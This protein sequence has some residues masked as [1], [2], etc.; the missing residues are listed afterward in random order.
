MLAAAMAAAF[1]WHASRASVKAD[2]PEA[3]RTVPGF[4]ALLGRSPETVRGMDVAQL[5]LWSAEGLPGAEGVDV[6]ASMT[7]L[8]NMAGRARTETERHIYRFKAN[9]AEFE[10]SEGFFRMI[11]L[12]VVLGEDFQVKYAAGKIGTAADAWTGDGFFSDASRGF[13]HGLSGPRREGTCSSLPVLYVAVGRRLGYP[14]KLVTT[15]GYLFVRW[16]D[17]KERFNIEATSRGVNR[18][19]DEYYRHWPLEVTEVEIAAE[20]YLKS[21]SPAEELAV[22]LSIRGMCLQEAGRYEEAA[23]AFREAARF[24]PGCRS[25]GVMQMEME[26]KAT[27]AARKAMA[28]KT[29]GER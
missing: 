21:L 20:G 1:S 26:R 27:G 7:L 18:F 3:A 8:G 22:F 29:K 24:A 6:E 25:Y 14:L 2:E 10:N 11:M 17:G 13:L 5:N 9:P 12:G 23:T 15:K 4:D 19:P 16:Q 28:P